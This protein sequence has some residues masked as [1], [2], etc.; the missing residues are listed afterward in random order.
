MSKDYK[1]K[2]VLGERVLFRIDHLPAKK[3]LIWIPD[4]ERRKLPSGVVKKL[5]MGYEGEVKVGQRYLFDHQE[6]VRVDKDHSLVKVD[7]LICRVDKGSPE[8]IDA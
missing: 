2:E 4:A 7:T 1:I 5:P 8:E 3:G 6:S